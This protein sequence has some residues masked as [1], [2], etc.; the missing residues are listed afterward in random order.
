MSKY[1]VKLQRLIIG[2]FH[3]TYTYTSPQERHLIHGMGFSI[4]LTRQYQILSK[5]AEYEIP[6]MKRADRGIDSIFS[7]SVQLILFL[8]RVHAAV[9]C[10]CHEGLW[11]V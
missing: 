10:A 4:P 7:A 3:I 2:H 1:V 11:G 9:F 8:Q 5:S 6:C